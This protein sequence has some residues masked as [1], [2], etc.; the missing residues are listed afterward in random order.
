M[1]LYKELSAWVYE[2]GSRFLVSVVHATLRPVSAGRGVAVLL[3][4]S[5]LGTGACTRN[6]PAVAK[7]WFTEVELQEV[8]PADVGPNHAQVLR[9]SCQGALEREIAEVEAVDDR[10]PVTRLQE[11][12]DQRRTYVTGTPG[13]YDVHLGRA[14]T[15]GCP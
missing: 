4:V 15:G 7:T 1:V 6:A 12:R 10:D 8:D 5:F 13:D 2:L 3:L 14:F 11:Q 9:M